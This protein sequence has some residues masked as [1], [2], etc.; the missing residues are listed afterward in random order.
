MDKKLMIQFINEGSKFGLC[1]FGSSSSK[2][3]FIRKG[4][5]KHTKTK[6]NYLII[7]YDP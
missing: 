7:H 6:Q 2:M 5:K 3:P 4:K 1:P